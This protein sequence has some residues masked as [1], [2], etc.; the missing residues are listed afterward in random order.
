MS[1][2]LRLQPGIGA[3]IFDAG[4]RV[5][6]HFRR[7]DR[8]WAPPSGSVRAGESLEDALRREID[9]EPTLS[10]DIAGLVGIYSDPS[11]Q[12]LPTSDGSRTHFI[13]CVFRCAVRDGTLHGSDEGLSW[14]WFDPHR[15]P[16]PLLPYARV[17]LDDAFTADAPRV[18]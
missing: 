4:G 3:V 17:W 9:E 18:R 10:I 7:D 11:F 5:L 1:L 13:T 14:E 15:L 12:V 8:G 6:L 16:D 2:P